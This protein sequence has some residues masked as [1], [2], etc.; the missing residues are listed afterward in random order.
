MDSDKLTL[1]LNAKDQF[2]DERPSAMAFNS[3][4]MFDHLTETVLDKRTLEM[5]E[6][7]E[8]YKAIN[9]TQTLVGAARLFHSLHSPSASLDVI[10]AKQESLKELDSNDKLRNAVEAYIG[11]FSNREPDLF[12]FLNAHYLPLYPYQP[13]KDAIDATHHM[14]DA[15]KNIPQPETSYLDSL[16]K[17]IKNYA[18]TP[19]SKLVRE[20]TYRTTQGLKIR[21]EKKFFSPSLRFRPGR[22]SG[23]SIAPSLPC[24]FAA[25]AGLA[26]LIEY[27]V[28][29]SLVLLTGGGIILGAVYAYLLKPIFDDETAILPIRQRLLDSNHFVSAIE[30]VACIDELLSFHHYRKNTPHNTVI[31]IL[32]DTERHFLVAS[33]LKNPIIAKN[34]P[35]YIGNDINLDNFNLTFITGPNSGGKTT[36]CKTIAQS[37]L[38]GQIGAPI[39]ADS[40]KMNIADKISYQAPAFDSLSDQEG[41]FG[42]ELRRTKEIFFS[43]TPKSLVILDEIAEG[44]SIHEKLPVSTAILNGFYDKVTNTI[45]VTHSYDLVESFKGINRGQ[46]LQ[47]EFK[48]DEPTHRVIPGIS[49]DSHAELVVRKIGFSPADIDRHLKENGYI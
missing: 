28:A 29:K 5:L 17:I 25:G 20:P 49:W 45:L 38:L 21:S 46:C 24:L 10:Q 14:V 35:N 2:I 41:R 34:D 31:P 23:G 16:F 6:I 43:A 19:E 7:H 47:V 11:E 36:L 4:K 37:Q 30:A 40:A 9:H 13:L 26:G 32:G 1:E 12:K 18:N 39:V 44:T 42:T 48:N 15:L 8:L 22:L 33:N 27:A 3:T